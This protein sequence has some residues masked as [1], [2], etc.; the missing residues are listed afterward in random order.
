MK[1]YG[2]MKPLITKP[3]TPITQ[4]VKNLM[5]MSECL[6]SN[7]KRTIGSSEESGPS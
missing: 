1:R 4:T 2:K 7:L 3:F 6:T 5:A